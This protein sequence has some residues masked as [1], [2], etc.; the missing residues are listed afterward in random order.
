MGAAVALSLGLAGC[1]INETATYTVTDEGNIYQLDSKSRQLW[2][3]LTVED[4][5]S[6]WAGNLLRAQVVLRNID[7]DAESL[8]YKFKWYDKDGFEVAGDGRPWTP[9]TISGHES[10]AIQ[11]VAPNPTVQTFRVMVLD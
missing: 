10:K 6:G 1:Q 3:G 8:K 5:R 7:D 2:G 9:I 11:A 4:V